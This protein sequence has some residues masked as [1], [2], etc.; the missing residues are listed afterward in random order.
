MFDIPEIFRMQG[1]TLTSGFLNS[2]CWQVSQAIE[3]NNNDLLV[4]DEKLG[5]VGEICL[6]LGE[7]FKK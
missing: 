2:Q 7:V 1:C 4:F 3:I 5:E 6:I